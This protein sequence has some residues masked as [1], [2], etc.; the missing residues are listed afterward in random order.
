MKPN[1]NLRVAIFINAF[2]LFGK[3]VDRQFYLLLCYFLLMINK[4]T[5]TC[6]ENINFRFTAPLI[7]CMHTPRSRYISFSAPEP[8]YLITLETT[9]DSLQGENRGKY[10][11]IG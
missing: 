4:D 9:D 11:P 10:T 2:L 3:F 5:K 1:I 8:F 7:L 6:T